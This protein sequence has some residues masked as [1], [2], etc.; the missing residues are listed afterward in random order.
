MAA[1]GLLW[2]ALAPGAAAGIL[3]EAELEGQALRIELGERAGLAIVTVGTDRYLVD[4]QGQTVLH[5]A[6]SI[7]IAAPTGRAPSALKL[8]PWYGG[9]LIAGYGSTY[10]ILSRE[11]AICAEVAVAGWTAQ[12]LRPAADA[13]ALVQQVDGRLAAEDR[14]GCG[15]IPFASFASQGWPLMIGWRDRAIFV[16]TALRFDHAAPPDLTPAAEP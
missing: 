16:T 3:I 1:L 6:R 12:L 14:G 13:L 4:L 5:G 11:G 2:A 7:R 8:E 15:P 10:H 9:P